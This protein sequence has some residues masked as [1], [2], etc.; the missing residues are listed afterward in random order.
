M[1]LSVIYISEW[2]SSL[3]PFV[4]VCFKKGHPVERRVGRPQLL[5]KAGGDTEVG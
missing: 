2:M 1:L 5:E 4:R 3:D